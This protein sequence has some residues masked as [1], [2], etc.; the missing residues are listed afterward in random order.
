MSKVASSDSSTM[1]IEGNDVT[2]KEQYRK[3]RLVFCILIHL[4]LQKVACKAG[5]WMTNKW[6]YL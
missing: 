2:G 3:V 5:E 6:A 4:I 1:G